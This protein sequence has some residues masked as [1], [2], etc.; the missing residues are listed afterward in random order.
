MLGKTRALQVTKKKTPLESQEVGHFKRVDVI[1]SCLS[2]DFLQRHL[3]M[4]THIDSEKKKKKKN[5]GVRQGPLSTAETDE[6]SW[7]NPK[8]LCFLSSQ[9]P[10]LQCLRNQ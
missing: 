10:D 5:P 2:N 4:I 8:A 7:Q 9:S 6:A 3:S 1:F